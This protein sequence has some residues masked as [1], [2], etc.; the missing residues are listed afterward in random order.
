MKV[1]EYDLIRWLDYSQ[2]IKNAGYSWQ[3]KSGEIQTKK[4]NA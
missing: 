4:S 3:S 1:L 2:E